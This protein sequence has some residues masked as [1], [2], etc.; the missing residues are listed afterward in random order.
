MLMKKTSDPG[1]K[2]ILASTRGRAPWVLALL[3]LASFASQ[4]QA[5]VSA[6]ISSPYISYSTYWFKDTTTAA[7]GVQTISTTYSTGSKSQSNG[8]SSSRTR[9]VS[10]GVVTVM[11]GFWIQ[12]DD[13]YYATTTFQSQLPNGSTYTSSERHT[14]ELSADYSNPNGSG[15]SIDVEI[16]ANLSFINSSG[17]A[18]GTTTE[19]N[20]KIDLLPG[21]SGR[22]TVSPSSGTR[23]DSYDASGIYYVLD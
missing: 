5:Q 13:N 22:I 6:W 1:T 20:D 17:N 10:N 8:G 21:N 9:Y 16:S 15:T 4:A 3:F 12:T 19:R 14:A 23:T 11:Y 7:N 2:P 18:T